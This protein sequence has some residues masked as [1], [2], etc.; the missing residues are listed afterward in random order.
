MLHIWCKNLLT[1]LSFYPPSLLFLKGNM[2]E[3]TSLCVSYENFFFN[4]QFQGLILTAWKWFFEISIFLCFTLFSVYSKV[5]LNLI[6]IL[7]ISFVTVPIKKVPSFSCARFL[8]RKQFSWSNRVAY[9]MTRYVR[10]SLQS[11]KGFAI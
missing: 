8:M 10:P 11:V 2:N 4:I 3:R 9:L 7:Q 5:I 6:W 1:H